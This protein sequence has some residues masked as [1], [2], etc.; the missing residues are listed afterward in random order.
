MH[1]Q[2]IGENMGLDLFKEIYMSF[3]CLGQFSEA[4]G[5]TEEGR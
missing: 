1:A 2:I 5:Q 3:L 4:H